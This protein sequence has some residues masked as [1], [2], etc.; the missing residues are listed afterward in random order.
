MR[1][2]GTIGGSLAHAD[3]A[4]DLGS[5]MLA[6]G[7]TRRAQAAAGGEREVPIAEFLVDTFTTSIEPNELA[8]RDP[9][10]HA[11]APAPAATT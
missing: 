9:R 7:G 3:P 5:V 2:L 1:N 11:A 8:H 10:P 6:L 4:G